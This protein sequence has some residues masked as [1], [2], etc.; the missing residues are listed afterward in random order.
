MSRPSHKQHRRGETCPGTQAGNAGATGVWSRYPSENN[1]TCTEWKKNTAVKANTTATPEDR[2]FPIDSVFICQRY[3][4][5]RRAALGEA[6]RVEDRSGL[7]L[8]LRHGM[9]HWIKGI[10]KNVFFIKDQPAHRRCPADVAV[11]QQNI[12]LSEVPFLLRKTNSVPAKGSA[13]SSLRQIPVRPS[14]PLRKSTGS[15]ASRIRICG[16][17][18]QHIYQNDSAIA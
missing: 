15:N 17:D 2:V 10:S 9:L 6:I 4:K 16:I 11:S 1:R 8:F 5:L 14:I 13:C 12:N 7:V 18:L 3:E